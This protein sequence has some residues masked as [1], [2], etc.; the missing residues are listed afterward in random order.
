MQM[1]TIVADENIPALDD[2]LV[3][4]AIAITI[5][6]IPGRRITNDDLRDAD[7][8]LVR[9]VTV[10]DAQLLQGNNIRFVGSCTIGTDHIDLEYLQQ[11]D[12]PFA[13]APGCNADAVVDYVLAAM[14]H[15]DSD[16]QTWRG[17]TA[18]IV[19]LGQVGRRLQLRL[20]KLGLQVYAFDPFVAEARASYANVLRADVVSF[21]V[22]LTRS[23]EHPTLSML[24][25]DALAALKPGGLLIN[26]CRGPVFDNAALTDFLSRQQTL[27]NDQRTTVV[28]DVYAEEPAPSMALLQSVALSTSHIAGYSEQGKLRGTIQVLQ[29][30]LE[31]LDLQLML[32][33]LLSRTRRSLIVEG[34]S[35]IDIVRKAYDIHADS[36]AFRGDYAKAGDPAAQALSFDYYRKHYAVRTEWAYFD[37]DTDGL[38]AKALTLLAQLGFPV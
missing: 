3:E 28:L 12:I 10:V 14:L 13:N 11:Q 25:Y 27:A 22:P 1:L 31:A 15:H 20:Q 18:G 33:D 37:I 36:K 38:S 17:K 32:P 24:G 2:L 34:M 9:S 21:H 29:A 16:I 5:R 8:L 35:P 26:S 19:G 7:V 6:R 30:M 4:A 23:G